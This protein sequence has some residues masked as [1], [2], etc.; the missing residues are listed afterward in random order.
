MDPDSDAEVNVRW[1]DGSTS[2]YIKAVSLAE[3][4]VA[5]QRSVADWCRTGVYGKYEG[6]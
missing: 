1:S 2:E 3:A 5:D 4:S 6:R